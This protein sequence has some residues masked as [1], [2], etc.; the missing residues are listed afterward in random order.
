MAPKPKDEQNTY[1]LAIY[2]YRLTVTQILTLTL[3]LNP[4]FNLNPKPNSDANLTLT[5][6]QKIRRNK[7]LPQLAKKIL[8]ATNYQQER[9]YLVN[10]IDL[11]TIY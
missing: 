5:L 11:Q 1:I 8:N 7:F 4:S 10:N 6:T 3:T 2:N 9:L